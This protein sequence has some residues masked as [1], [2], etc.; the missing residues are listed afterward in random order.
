MDLV[1][2]MQRKRLFYVFD[3]PFRIILNAFHNKVFIFKFINL[4]VKISLE[5]VHISIQPAVFTYTIYKKNVSYL[6]RI[7][8]FRCARKNILSYALIITSL[9]WL[10]TRTREQHRALQYIQF[11]ATACSVKCF[12]KVDK[13]RNIVS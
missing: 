7:H 8:S 6:T 4:N 5:A 2:F 12:L 9:N 3:L 10:I 13:P 11:S 1:R